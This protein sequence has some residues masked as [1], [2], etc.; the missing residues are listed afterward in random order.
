MTMS[1]AQAREIDYLTGVA[2]GIRRFAWW[3]DGVQ[4]VGS[5]AMTLED[6]LAEVDAQIKAVES[7]PTDTAQGALFDLP[8]QPPPSAIREGR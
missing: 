4:Y 6:A 3:K 5:G 2:A 1:D 8:K 7:T